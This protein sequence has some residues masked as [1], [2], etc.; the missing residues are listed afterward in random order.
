MVFS[1][2][3]P[4]EMLLKVTICAERRRNASKFTKVN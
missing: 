2:Q 1:N 4:L 3:N